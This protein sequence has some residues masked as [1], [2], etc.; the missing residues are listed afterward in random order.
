MQTT[1]KKI[2]RVASVAE[3]TGLSKSTIYW[4]IRHGKFPPSISLGARSAGW[5]EAD[6]DA[7]IDERVRASRGE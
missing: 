1:T 4:N 5:L 7:W 6:I 2:L 3:R